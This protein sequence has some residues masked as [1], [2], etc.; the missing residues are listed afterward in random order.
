[1]TILIYIQNS[2]DNK[3]FKE[4]INHTGTPGIPANHPEAVCPPKTP[5]QPKDWDTVPVLL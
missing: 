2:I 3:P 5:G 1:M 4:V